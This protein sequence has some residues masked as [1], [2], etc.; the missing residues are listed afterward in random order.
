MNKEL[1]LKNLIKKKKS[2]LFEF[3]EIRNETMPVLG[4]YLGYPPCCVNE[5]S[6]NFRKKKISKRKLSGTGYVPCFYCNKKTTEELLS[7]I[8]KNRICSDEF[9]NNYNNINVS[10]VNKTEKLTNNEKKIIYIWVEKGK[11]LNEV[12]EKINSKKKFSFLDYIK[13][14]KK[15]ISPFNQK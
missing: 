15:K 13:I 2:L 10:M 12:L 5:F 1:S 11:V 9:P 7:E 6:N 4:K 14:F 3:N 8:R